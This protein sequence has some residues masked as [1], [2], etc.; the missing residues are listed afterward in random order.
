MINK[1]NSWTSNEGQ[2]TKTFKHLYATNPRTPIAIVLMQKRN[3]KISIP[4]TVCSLHQLFY[5]K[6][7]CNKIGK[8]YPDV[9]ID[10][11]LDHGCG[12]ETRLV[13]LTQ[14]S[15]LTGPWIMD[16]VSK[17]DWLILPR[18]RH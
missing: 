9:V 18:C 3:T 4:A 14:M 15:L 12:M 8:F 5:L 2:P 17:Q 11:T 7:Q 16:V 1:N 6:T 13:N 10:W